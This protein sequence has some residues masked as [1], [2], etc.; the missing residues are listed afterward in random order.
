MYSELDVRDP[1]FL[2]SSN[3]TAPTSVRWEGDPPFLTLT[4][5]EHRAGPGWWVGTRWEVSVVLAC[6]L[7]PGCLILSLGDYK[8]QNAMYYA[9][10]LIDHA[11]RKWCLV[12]ELCILGHVVLAQVGLLLAV[13]CGDLTI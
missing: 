11:W 1:E 6:K 2:H 12:V 8:S 3:R 4:R 10:F 5:A 13:R 7:L 9:S